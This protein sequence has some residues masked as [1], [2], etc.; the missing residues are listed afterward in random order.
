MHD[1]GYWIDSVD[2]DSWG[3]RKEG[4]EKK[5]WIK[6]NQATYQTVQHWRVKRQEKSQLEKSPETS[7]SFF[8][9]PLLIHN[10]G[11]GNPWK[12]EEQLWVTQI[13]VGNDNFIIDDCYQ[14]WFSWCTLSH[15]PSLVGFQLIINHPNESWC[16]VDDGLGA[17]SGQH[18]LM[19]SFLTEKKKKN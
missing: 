12:W 4:G 14:R 15:R 9:F 16:T 3:S 1:L 17:G 19:F 6:I 5:E 18:A 2:S 13:L 11:K 10:W 7:E 8:L